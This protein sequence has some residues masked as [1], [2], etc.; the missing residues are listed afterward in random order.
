MEYSL[1]ACWV[2]SNSHPDLLNRM[3]IAWDK[4]NIPCQL[5]E[6]P[7]DFKICLSSERALE[8]TPA[9]VFIVNT[10]QQ[11]LNGEPAPS[12]IPPLPCSSL[13]PNAVSGCR[14]AFL[15]GQKW[16]QGCAAASSQAGRICRVSTVSRIKTMVF[17]MLLQFGWWCQE[18]RK[19]SLTSFF[20]ASSYP[21]IFKVI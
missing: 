11:N 4:K 17:A 16:L 15:V 21:F 14:K 10:P 12:S 19:I 6:K 20:L 18:R 3:E 2:W 9:E 13:T 5:S 7:K 8:V 1:G